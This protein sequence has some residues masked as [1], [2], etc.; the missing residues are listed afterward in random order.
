MKLASSP[1]FASVR[2]WNDE[3]LTL[4]THRYDYLWAQHPNPGER[5]DWQ[6]ESPSPAE[7]SPD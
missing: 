5:P 4:W 1:L 7:R 2:D 6:T 3:F